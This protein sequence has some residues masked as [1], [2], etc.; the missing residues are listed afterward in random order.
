MPRRKLSDDVERAIVTEIA[1]GTPVQEIAAKL[2]I[3][4]RT[5]YRRKAGLNPSTAEQ[6]IPLR[7]ARAVV[8]DLNT[9]K[10]ITD[11]LGDLP[12]WKRQRIAD[13]IADLAQNIFKRP[14]SRRPTIVIRELKSAHDQLETLL[15]E[16]DQIGE[17]VWMYALVDVLWQES[18]HR[19]HL[20]S[21]LT[22]LNEAIE[23]AQAAQFASGKKPSGRRR[24]Q[25][26]GQLIT[27]LA[28]IYLRVTGKPP[29]HTVDPKTGYPISDFNKFV[30]NCISKFVPGQHINWRAVREQMRFVTKIY[31]KD[32]IG[33]R[34]VDDR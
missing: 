21:L 7:T 17:D 30:L 12:D 28:M 11:H 20:H 15:T 29:L 32:F 34:S 9:V 25:R 27:A 18:V 24:D 14:G 31:W 8:K 10:R 6:T 22:N 33:N 19:D 13:Q 2:G 23:V 4:E 1:A 5:V 3:N 16:F 26:I